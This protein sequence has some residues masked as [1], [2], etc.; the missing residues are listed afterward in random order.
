MK[1]GILTAKMYLDRHPSNTLA[2]TQTYTT[3]P[4]TLQDTQ[5]LATAAQAENDLDEYE[6]Q[7]V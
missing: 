6:Y 3:T 7:V 4:T 2:R 1:R 5:Y